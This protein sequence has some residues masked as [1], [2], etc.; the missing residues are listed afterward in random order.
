MLPEISYLQLAIS[1]LLLVWPSR[2]PSLS[3]PETVITERIPESL[4]SSL[5][6]AQDSAT[7][8]QRRLTGLWGFWFG[9]LCGLLFA[10]VLVG[11]I[12]LMR[13]LIL[14][15]LTTRPSAR[16]FTATN[17][18]QAHSL[19]ALQYTPASSSRDL[20]PATPAQLRAAGLT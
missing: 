2:C 20:Q 16:A 9:F 14:H 12:C 10:A 3:C 19:P 4:T 6:F 11:F 7:E 13:G 1:S 15:V 8:C 17:I 5:T 18:L